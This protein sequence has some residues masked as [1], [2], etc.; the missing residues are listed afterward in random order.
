MNKGLIF[1][2][3]FPFFFFTGPVS[4]VPVAEELGLSGDGLKNA[5]PQQQMGETETPTLR[6]DNSQAPD[7]GLY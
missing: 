1:F 3:L 5:W 2:I 7:T 6:L 4:S